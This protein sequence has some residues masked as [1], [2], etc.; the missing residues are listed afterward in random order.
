MR[1]GMPTPF[2]RLTAVQLV[3]HQFSHSLTEKR[4]TLREEHRL[5]KTTAVEIVENL[6][7][8]T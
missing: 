6:D 4:I 8:G 3:V 2:V 1:G 5:D 7:L